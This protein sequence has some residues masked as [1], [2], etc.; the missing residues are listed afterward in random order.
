MSGSVDK[1][2]RIAKAQAK[3]GAFAEAEALYR[4]V[5]ARFPSNKRAQAGLAELQAVRGQGP[6]G[7][8]PRAM[9]EELVGLARARRFRDLVAATAP[10]LARFPRAEPILEL[11]AV[12]LLNIGDH[13]GAADLYKQLADMRPMD[14]EL[15]GKLGNAQLMGGDAEGAVETFSRLLELPPGD[16]VAHNN[17]G[18]LLY[19]RGEV[20]EARR[21]IEAAVKLAPDNPNLL[22]LLGNLLKAQ[23]DI[24]GAKAQFDAALTLA[25]KSAAIHLNRALVQKFQPGDPQIATLEALH[26]NPSTPVSDRSQFGFALAKAYEDLG[27]IE[28]SYARLKQA[29]A[30]RKAEIGYDTAQ[31][32][33][34]FDQIRKAFPAPHAPIA[35]LEAP[36]GPEPIFIL[37][38][39]RSGTTL[40]EQI[41][42]S[43]PDVVAGGERE[44]LN[45]ALKALD[46]SSVAGFEREGAKIEAS[47]REMLRRFGGEAGFVTDKMPSNF[48]WIG[49]IRALFPKARIVHVQRDPRAVLWS[50]YKMRF[51]GTGYGF[52]YD[53][54]DLVAYHGLYRE[55][56]AH[57][58]ALFG[59]AVIDVDYEA[60]TAD[61]EPA[62]RA[63]ISALG[64]PWT[65]ACLRPQDNT[66]AVNTASNLQVRRAIYTGSSQDWQR[67]AHLIGEAFA[68]LPE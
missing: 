68:G 5:L 52:G 20:P 43:H 49:A 45:S 60:L 17:L 67:Y 23:G 21:H 24:E 4:E 54:G 47:Y 14:V 26:R 59:D 10:A 62:I 9:I 64:L 42:S 50:I 58:R 44:E 56:M 61:P 31:S 38:L 18:K 27:E 33:K 15:L 25:P 29:N 53:F 37:G 57:W 55:L 28:R 46:W 48:L 1:T 22:D 51:T 34:L 36:T 3:S 12:G 65:E 16:A 11:R 41:I 13:R 66:R 40:I 63:L 32:R 2:L 8:P 19:L 6:L 35:P 39:P 30:E 7:Q